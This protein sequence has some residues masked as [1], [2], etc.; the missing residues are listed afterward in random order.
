MFLNSN[1]NKLYNKVMGFCGMFRKRAYR[2]NE[3]VVREG[4]EGSSMRL[5]IAGE[6]EVGKR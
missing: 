3:G 5:I 6:V 2:C 4:E 1:S